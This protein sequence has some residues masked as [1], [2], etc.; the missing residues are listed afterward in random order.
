MF[1][2]ALLFIALSVSAYFRTKARRT[3]PERISRREEGKFLLVALRLGGLML[4]ISV[5]A[6]AINPAWMAWSTLP[7][8]VWVRWLGVLGGLI[9]IPLVMWM[10][11]SLGTNVT[12]TVVTRREAS[13]VTYG[14]YRYI[15]HPLYTFGALFYFSLSLIAAS[16]WIA[17]LSVLAL[18]LLSLRTPIEEAKLIERF[19]DDYRQYM[20]R[21]GRFFPKLSSLTQS[22]AESSSYPKNG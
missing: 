19:G 13:L 21:T 11:R 1:F 17:L 10:F 18:L 9:S 16:W 22:L 3:S 15:R 20:E 8:P 7:L 4:M 2:I 5:L 6:Y 12:D 14:P